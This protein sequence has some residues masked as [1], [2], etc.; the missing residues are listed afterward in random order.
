MRPDLKS[1]FAILVHVSQSG[2]T[3][4]QAFDEAVGAL[5]GLLQK[6]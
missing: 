1:D 4:F 3:A 6:Q 2:D 5:I